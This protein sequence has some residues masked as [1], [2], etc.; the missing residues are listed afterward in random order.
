MDYN[1]GSCRPFQIDSQYLRTSQSDVAGRKYGWK[2]GRRRLLGS[3]TAASSSG[4]LRER[5]VVHAM[6]GQQIETR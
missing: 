4:V 3:L 1:D 6:L 5:E 2:D